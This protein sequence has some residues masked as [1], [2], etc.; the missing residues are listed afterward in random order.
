MFKIIFFTIF[1]TPI[2]GQT[3]KGK[4]IDSE[5]KQPVEGATI[6][7]V[8]TKTNAVSNENGTF[9]VTNLDIGRY[10]IEVSSLGYEK[11]IIN[12]ILVGVGKEVELNIQLIGSFHQFDELT[13]NAKKEFGTS[14][15][16]MASSSVRSFSVEQTKR[17]AASW[18][19]PARMALS[20]AGTSNINDQTN[21]II[22]RGNSPKGM[23]WK[24]EGVEIPNPNHFGLDG[25]S[26]GGFSAIS[27]NVLGNSDFYIGA[28]PAEY[29]NATSGIFD[30]HLRNGNNEKREHSL[31]VGFQGIEASTE[32]F[33]TKKS[34]ASYLVNYRVFTLGVLG[35]MGIKPA[36]SFASPFFQDLAFKVNIP[37]KK[38]VASIWGIGGKSDSNFKIDVN[39]KQIEESNFFATGINFLTYLNKK[40]Y[41]E[42]IISGSGNILNDQF[43]TDIISQK[44]INSYLYL[45]YSSQFNLKINNKN[46]LRLGGV[47]TNMNFKFL[48][49]YGEK[50]YSNSKYGEKGQAQLYQ[51]YG[52][53]KN[54]IFEKININPGLHFTYFALNNT[55]SLEPRLN[56]KLQLTSKKT[57]SLGIGNHS[58]I[59][60]LPF[61]MVELNHTDSSHIKNENLQ[62]PKSFHVVLGYEY[63]PNSSW[64]FL[65]ETY[66]QKQF[67]QAIFA[68]KTNLADLS[69]Y[70]SL[71]D[72]STYTDILASNKGKGE[73]YGVEFTIEKFL[74]D[75]FYLI[76]TTS[77]FNATYSGS[78]GI[79]RRSRFSNNF[80][81]N[82][83]AGKEW[84]IG[85]KKS[86]ILGL[87]IRSTWAGGLRSTPILL[88]ESRK[89][90]Y[91][92]YDYSKIYEKKL[93]NFFRTDFK[94][95][96]IVNRNKT[97]STFSL[98]VNNLTNHK[99]PKHIY[100]DNSTKSEVIIYQL[101]ILPVFNYRLEF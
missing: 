64:R 9:R 33:F 18:G 93:D 31:Q 54:R 90:G 41:I 67:D 78:D 13:I 100:Y 29:G 53:W 71:N 87:N 24:I 94:V 22:I 68:L 34:K 69:T 92:I 37:L 91:G 40:A 12:E 76:N 39:T 58:R 17:Y 2:F 7:F 66:L 30:I 47:L 83:L 97:T 79:K 5:T 32:G 46:S 6:L 50:S 49:K 80:V 96:Y 82:F 89:V 77:L 55:S 16:D 72:L 86:N 42:N 51:V 95:N 25:A 60:P 56:A 36:G 35:K 101:G 99:N 26:G 19:D 59:H 98:D 21:E 70:S 62:I 81:E 43:Q 45:R 15:N 1:I 14:L 75:G 57:F 4:I 84:N 65:V 63:R 27:T 88:D 52:Q 28:F 74:T 48:N 73:N 38:T 8:K 85:N 20:F 3:I 44:K 11:T 23:L 61:Y 10:S